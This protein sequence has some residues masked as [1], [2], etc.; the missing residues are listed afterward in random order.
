MTAAI[1]GIKG[2]NERNE[3]ENKQRNAWKNEKNG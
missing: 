3:W 2:M 1:R